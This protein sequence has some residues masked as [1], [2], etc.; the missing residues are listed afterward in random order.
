MPPSAHAAIDQADQIVSR[1]VPEL[2]RLDP[3]EQHFRIPWQHGL[4]LF[5]R[6]LG[7]PSAQSTANI[8]LYAHGATFPS[9][10]SIAHRFDGH[11]WRDALNGSGFHVWGL[12]FIGYGG[13]DRYPEMFQPSDD[14]STLG[15]AEAASQQIEKA[16][17][18][19]LQFHQQSR[20]SII[21][22]SW[23]SMAVALFA[24]RHPELVERIVFFAPI[25]QRLKQ[26]EAK[27]FPSWRLVS[28]QEQWDRFTEDVPSGDA[29]LSKRHF[30]QWGSLYLDTD[31]ESRTRTPASVKVP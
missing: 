21:A 4:N 27:R 14:R 24:G 16:A 13:S 31:S 28:L 23:G 6:Y 12:D 19:I 10:L 29:V 3:R 8:V 18:F 1:Q 22:H 15:R 9:A 20:M 26:S 7:P 30:E 11:S 25:A 2:P 5:L 17:E